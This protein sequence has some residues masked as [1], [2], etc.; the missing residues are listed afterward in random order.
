MSLLTTLNDDTVQSLCSHVKSTVKSSQ[1]KKSYKALHSLH[2]AL[3]VWRCFMSSMNQGEADWETQAATPGPSITVS[4]S[5]CPDH[6]EI[7]VSGKTASPVNMELRV[8]LCQPPAG[9]AHNE[10]W[11][12]LHH[13]ASLKSVITLMKRYSLLRF[14]LPNLNNLFCWSL[15]KLYFSPK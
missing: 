15:S 13:L 3:H 8:P 10:A 5:Y 7:P 9:H 2:F 12:I 6:P 11:P 14:Y 1:N 4:S